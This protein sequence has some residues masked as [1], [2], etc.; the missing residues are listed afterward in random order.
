MRARSGRRGPAAERPRLGRTT[1]PVLQ[2]LAVRSKRCW[3]LDAGRHPHPRARKKDGTQ[4]SRAGREER[5]G[6]RGGVLALAARSSRLAA[7]SPPLGT[8]PGNPCVTLPQRRVTRHRCASPS[9]PAGHSERQRRISSPSR[10]TPGAPP[11]ASQGTREERGREERRRPFG[12]AQGRPA[13]ALQGLSH[14]SGTPGHTVALFTTG[15]PPEPNMSYHPVSAP[16]RP[17][18]RQ[19]SRVTPIFPP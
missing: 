5:L 9:P 11:A 7:S 18:T 10:A 16:R 19:A 3:M 6:G 15:R 17:I 14:S 13:A 2:V 12:F 8:P 1:L 4:R